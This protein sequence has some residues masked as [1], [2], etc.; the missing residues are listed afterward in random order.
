MAKLGRVDG[1]ATV[2]NPTDPLFASSLSP[3]HSIGFAT[4]VF[5]TETNRLPAGTLDQLKAAVVPATA[6]P[7]CRCAWAAR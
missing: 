5:R 6:R 4:V 2:T 1:V 7:A 3:D